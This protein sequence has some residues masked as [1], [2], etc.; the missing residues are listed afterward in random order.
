MPFSIAVWSWLLLP[1][2]WQLVAAAAG[3]GG[4]AAGGGEG[5]GSDAKLTPFKGANI[6]A[7]EALHVVG[8]DFHTHGG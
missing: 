2:S 3:G 7:P 6:E 8:A 5:L 1:A 4:G